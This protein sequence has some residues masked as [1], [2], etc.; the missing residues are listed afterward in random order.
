MDRY[1]KP[2]SFRSRRMVPSMASTSFRMRRSPATTRSAVMTCA[3]ISLSL[4]PNTASRRSSLKVA[5]GKEQVKAGEQARAKSDAKYYFGSPA[6]DV[7]V[8]W[9]L[10][11]Q[12]TYF[13]LPGYQTGVIADDW[14]VPNWAKGGNFGRTLESGT[15]RTDADGALTLDFADIPKSD[16]PQTLTLELTAQDESGFPVSARA[17]MTVHPADFYI[18]LRPDQWVGQ[19]GEAIGF[20]VYTADW[21]TNASPSQALQA[22][23]KKVRWERVS[24]PPEDTFG[25]P[26]Y[27][28]VYTLVGSSNLSTGADGKAPPLIYT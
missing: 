23:F 11:A 7:D 2:L 18:G 19:S 20:G 24:S 1:S 10:F 6:G 17:E 26:T 14:L 15:A 13:H 27:K 21:D 4:W 9:N 8:N 22:E 16:A 28:P 3:L 5:F 12:P 25:V